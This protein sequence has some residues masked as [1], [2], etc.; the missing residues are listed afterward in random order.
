[1]T[2]NSAFT[3]MMDAARVSSMTRQRKHAEILSALQSSQSSP[4]LIISPPPPPSPL[5]F[6]LGGGGTGSV[7]ISPSSHPYFF[8]CSK[9]S[10]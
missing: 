9:Q 4:V 5:P 2:P 8:G 1:M 3:A 10:K 6:P 7:V